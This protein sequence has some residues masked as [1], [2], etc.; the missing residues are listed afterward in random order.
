MG[1][2]GFVALVWFLITS[3]VVPHLQA[4]QRPPE[5]LWA[6]H[7]DNRAVD[8][9]NSPITSVYPGACVTDAA[10]NIFVTATFSG[11]VSLGGSSLTNTVPGFTAGDVLL[12]K[13]APDGQVLWVRQA[14]GN[15]ADLGRSLA[16]DGVGGVYV[17]GTTDSDT[18]LFGT[19]AISAGADTALF[20]ARYD[21]DGNCQW[22]RRAG[23]W[24]QTFSSA[25]NRS[26]V[27]DSGLVVD[28]VGNPVLGGRFN[29]NPMF[30]GTRVVSQ[31]SQLIYT[32]GIV[33]TNRML[34]LA[35]S[36]ED[37]FFAKF[38][39][40][41]NILWATN[42]G[43][44]NAEFASAIALDS[45]DN[46]YAS[47][48]FT[49]NTILGGAL[50]TNSMFLAKFSPAGVPVWSS[51]LSEPTNNNLG[52]ALS[53]VVDASNR[54][55]VAFSTAAP[56]FRL[57][58]NSFTN[59][60]QSPNFSG[61]TGSGLAQFSSNGALL[62]MK[63]TPFNVNGNSGTVGLSLSGD[64]ANNI[65]LRSV[66]NLMTNRFALGDPGLSVLKMQWEGGEFWTNTVKN[67]QFQTTLGDGQ[68]ADQ[69]GLPGISVAPNGRIAVIANVFGDRTTLGYI[70][71]TN[72]LAFTNGTG[73]NLLTY[74]IESN[75]SGV[76]PQFINQP[77][78]MVFQPPSALTN[79]ALARAWPVADYRWFSVTNGVPGRIG[80][81]QF[82]S[83]GATTVAN[84]TTYFVVASNLVGQS[85]STV[86]FAQAL[87]AILP[88]T[89]PT[90]AILLGGSGTLSINA[91]GT[92]AISYQWRFNGTNIVGATAPALVLNNVATNVGG[93]YTV[94][95]CND[96]GC[97]TSAPPITVR[98]IPPGSI[99]GTYITSLTGEYGMARLPDGRLLGA[100]G[101]LYPTLFRA[102]TN[103]AFDTNFY[104]KPPS[105]GG[106]YAWWRTGNFDQQG[107]R[108]FVG[109]PDGRIVVGGN[110]P[111]F[112]TN[113]PSGSWASVGKM[114][115]LTAD[116][117][118][119]R[120]FNVGGGPSDPSDAAG[121]SG[122]NA[123]VR[124][125]DGKLI[126]AGW[127]RN[128][129]GVA[130]T[131]IVRLNTNGTI[132]ATFTGQTFAYGSDYNNVG[133]AFALALQPDG[134][135][136][137]GGNWQRV[138]GQDRPVLI[139]LNTNGT[140][141]ESFVVMRVKNSS[142]T[143]PA[144]GFCIVN[145][146][147]LLSSGK[148]LIAGNGLRFNQTGYDNNAVFQLNADGT[149]DTNFV[150]IATGGMTASSIVA[151][152]PDGK[153]LLGGSPTV[154]RFLATGAADPDWKFDTSL[155]SPN[156]GRILIEP[157]GFTA[158][159]A[160][161]YGIRR[162]LTVD[163]GAV[164]PPGLPTGS[165]VRLPNGQFGFTT[166][167]LPGQAL[168]IQASTNLVNWDSISTNSSPGGCIDF[169]DTQAP[170]IPNRYYRVVILP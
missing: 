2:V 121:L 139:R 7:P 141:D 11:V 51:N 154:N 165:A 126:A 127:F 108:A 36:T 58:T 130:R 55:T 6:S 54:V 142:S 150:A 22:V 88:G 103:G 101:G 48:G 129:N 13:Y 64:T 17:S 132:D 60:V 102:L 30:G 44:T 33:L 53:V 138:S 37:I 41:G 104:L 32:N 151:V 15:Y 31:F 40:A 92:T 5:I 42:H 164:A 46:I 125:P 78:N 97:I 155:V 106:T 50:Y 135:V 26:S 24:Q 105:L 131:N 161:N 163:T 75:Y 157:G 140:L 70:G 146:I 12:I 16:L 62:W 1:S 89:N 115:R 112:F 145:S 152:Q 107:P 87:L 159:M 28:S 73:N 111:V 144:N 91:T 85:T 79:Y 96:W 94:V 77:T 69:R 149:V 57:G 134:K 133:N 99:D 143:W 169:I 86:V 118:L 59:E 34:S 137:V 38:S 4:Q 68:S 167:G 67:V 147:A 80:T 47:G 120:D 122:I 63:R 109:E 14:G 45:A 72:V 136:L 128:F 113:Y 29:G 81:N 160:G 95:A 66:A 162:I 124:Q 100:G 20:L 35:A 65:Y 123:L 19:N 76:L 21:A 43:T 27:R 168:V 90:N 56:I 61:V 117:L 114:V 148:I 39:P 83:L 23:A 158:L 52:T 82:L 170:L 9:V 8:G 116:G 166:C 153:I 71:W 119:D 156:T 18:A 93:L 49:K 110:F 74:Q 3:F 25:V 98:V 84:V 10:G